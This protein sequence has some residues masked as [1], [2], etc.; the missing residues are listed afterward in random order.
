MPSSVVSLCIPQAVGPSSCQGCHWGTFS[1]P[2]RVNHHSP[3]PATRFCQVRNGTFP[4]PPGLCAEKYSTSAID[5]L[6]INTRQILGYWT[7]KITRSP[8]FNPSPFNIIRS[9][10][11]WYI[12]SCRY[13]YWLNTFFKVKI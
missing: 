4:P 9:H 5:S 2:V 13:D 3:S 11:H 12:I 8:T 7:L 6:W 10:S 1:A